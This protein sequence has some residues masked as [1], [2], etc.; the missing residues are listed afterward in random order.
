VLV[1]APPLLVSSDAITIGAIVDGIVLVTGQDSLRWEALDDVI[2][3][4]SMCAA[5]TLGWVLT[6]AET[7]VGY[8]DYTSTN[9][10]S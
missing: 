7:L 5:P 10:R 8:A 4:L 6:G 9:G 2:R 1:D 3:A